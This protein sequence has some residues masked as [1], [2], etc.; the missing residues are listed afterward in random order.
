LS[1]VETISKGEVHRRYENLLAEHV[2]THNLK[3]QRLSMAVR[4]DEKLQ[5]CSD[6]LG[7]VV[8]VS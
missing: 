4:G 7:P 1:K 3:A 2:R 8:P 5:V 6:K